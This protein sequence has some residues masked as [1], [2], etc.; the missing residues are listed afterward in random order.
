VPLNQVYLYDVG[1][2][3]TFTPLIICKISG[4]GKQEAGRVRMTET[5]ERPEKES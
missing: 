4:F 3:E 5:N 2:F 1:H